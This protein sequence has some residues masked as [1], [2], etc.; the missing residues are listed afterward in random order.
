MDNVSKVVLDE[1]AVTGEIKPIIIYSD[2][3]KAA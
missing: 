1:T 3:H 2:A